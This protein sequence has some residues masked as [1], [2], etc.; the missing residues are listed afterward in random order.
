MK[1]KIF[2]LYPSLFTLHSFP[3]TLYNLM[4]YTEE[5]DALPEQS[6]RLENSIGLLQ[7]VK[8]KI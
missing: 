2:T 4:R 7:P 1:G 5:P 8:E 3:I 6:L